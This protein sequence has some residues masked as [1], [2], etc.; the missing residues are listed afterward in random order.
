MKN[1]KIYFWIGLFSTLTLGSCSDDFLDKD[2]LVDIVVENFYK[3]GSDAILAVNAAYSPA[4]WEFNNTYFNEW[5]LG[6]IV[7]DDAVKGGN[8]INDMSDLFQ[9]ENFN[10]TASSE[11]LLEFYRAQYQ[12]V[13][14]ANLAINNI[15]AIESDEDMNEQLK[16]RLLGE[17]HFLRAYYYFRLVRVFGGVPRITRTLAPSEYDQPRAS[18]DTIYQLIYNDLTEA[19]PGL[20]LKDEY[21]PED[22]G[23][24]TKGAAQAFLMKAYIYN[25]EWAKAKP[26]GDSIVASGQYDLLPDY[27]QNFTLEGE[28]GLESVFEI[29]YME[30][31][32]SDYGQGNGFTRGTFNIIMQ[33]TRVGSL[34]WG[35]NHP[36]LNLINEYETG[37]PRKTITIASPDGDSYL[38][39]AYHSKK[40]SLDGYILNHPTRGPL[41][42]KIIRYADVLLMLAEANCELNNLDEA[43]NALEEVRK[44]ARGISTSILPEFPYGSYADNQTDLRKAI[45]HE[46]RIELAMEGQ[47]FFDLVR[48]GV[49]AQVMN[50]YFEGE[51]STIK[52]YASPFVEGKHELFP[53]PEVEISL[54][55][56]ALEQNPNY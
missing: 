41:N 13:Y 23:R 19:I 53:I 15:P 28:N 9:L 10:G 3:T 30:E 12:G 5:M 25:K 37:D 18:R 35:F 33:R 34:G 8:G 32:T 2:P 45:R 14:K 55:H 51:S 36:S 38:G 24:V 54:S 4:Q 40:Y 22:L 42:Y 7:S 46:R 44:R 48:W 26:L 52:A 21:A 47:R 1:T 56:G 39:N 6:D 11:L 17:A 16:A 50:D 27:A 43:K 49:A 31:A 20:W 29:Q